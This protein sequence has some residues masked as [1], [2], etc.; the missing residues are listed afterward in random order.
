MSMTSGVASHDDATTGVITASISL[1]VPPQRVFTALTSGAEV[2]RWWGSRETY[3]LK[4]WSAEL[5][6]GGTWTT[7]GQRADGQTFDLTGT[8]LAYDPPWRL[9]KTW[10]PCL[11]PQGTE[12]T[13]T[14]QLS[15]IPGGTVLQVRHEG[16]TGRND[17]AGA[18]TS[19]WT[20]VLG[21]LQAALTL[22][23]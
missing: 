14:Y 10:R 16:F 15:A 3:V 13:L 19:G 20:Q 21:W 23:A 9:V 17:V 18:T 4:T 7:H 1:A 8:I 2:M 11:D 12:T 22:P 6:V 5:R